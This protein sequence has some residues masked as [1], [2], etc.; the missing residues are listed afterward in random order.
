MPLQCYR[1]DEEITFDD[2]HIS[3]FSGKH[4]PLDPDT[5]EPHDCKVRREMQE[6]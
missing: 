4:I 1:C 5:M 2:E 6:F 3:D